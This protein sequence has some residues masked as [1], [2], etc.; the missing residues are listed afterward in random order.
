MFCFFDCKACGII[1]ESKL[2]LL[3]PRQANKSKAR[4][5]GKEYDFTWRAGRPRSVNFF[6]SVAIHRWTG[7]EQKQK[8]RVT[9]GRPLCMDSILLV[10]KSRGSKGSKIQHGVRFILPYNS[11]LSV[12]IPKSYGKRGDEHSNCSISCIFWG[13]SII[14]ASVS[15]VEICLLLFFVKCLHV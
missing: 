11:P 6:L 8:G 13:M 1:M 4:C 2:T 9:W 3:T 7:P 14:S 15:N 10:N 12:S 5:W